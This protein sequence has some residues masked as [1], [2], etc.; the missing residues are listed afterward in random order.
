MD[1]ISATSN[2]R[3][4]LAAMLCASL[5]T[6]LARGLLNGPDVSPSAEESTRTVWI[7]SVWPSQDDAMCGFVTDH[8]NP[9][10]P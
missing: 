3:S 7:L 9:T 8:L 1:I 10:K 4:N 2:R 6:L 5:L